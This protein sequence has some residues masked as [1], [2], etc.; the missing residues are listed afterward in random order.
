MPDCSLTELLAVDSCFQSK[1]LLSSKVLRNYT[2]DKNAVAWLR[3]ELC[4]TQTA[5]TCFSRLHMSERIQGLCSFF[6]YTC[7]AFEYNVYMFFFFHFRHAS[8]Q[9]L[10]QPLSLLDSQVRCVCW[11]LCAVWLPEH[12]SLCRSSTKTFM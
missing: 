12:P 6:F 4:S 11:F 9:E 3:P 10:D 7:M 1:L 2:V 8:W 5:R